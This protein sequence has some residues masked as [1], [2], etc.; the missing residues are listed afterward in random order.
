MARQRLGERVFHTGT[1]LAALLLVR[2]ATGASGGGWWAAAAAGL[3]LSTLLCLVTAAKMHS[4]VGRRSIHWLFHPLAA[5][6][7]AAVLL[8]A[9][10]AAATGAPTRWR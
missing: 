9:A 10:R 6:A 5:A 3:A 2:P 1:L 8:G 4:A 7:V